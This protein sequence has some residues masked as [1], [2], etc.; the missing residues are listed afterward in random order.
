ML[1]NVSCRKY[2]HLALEHQ[3]WTLYQWKKVP[4][5]DKAHFLLNKLD[6]M[7]DMCSY[8]LKKEETHVGNGMSRAIFSWKPESF[9]SCCRLP[10][11]WQQSSM[12]P[13]GIFHCQLPQY[14]SC[15]GVISRTYDFT[16]F[17]WPSRS[18]SYWVGTV[19]F[20]LKKSIPQW[21][22]AQINFYHQNVS[23]Y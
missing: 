18:Q 23:Y 22:K 7:I 21:K 15:I 4:L 5:S 16:V 20:L 2:L 8:L 1:I 9:C 10:T 13:Y 6:G 12:M 3:N 14:T 11:S 17:L 19:M